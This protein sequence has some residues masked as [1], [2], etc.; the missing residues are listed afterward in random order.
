MLD[1]C[2]DHHGFRAFYRTFVKMMGLDQPSHASFTSH[3]GATMPGSVDHQNWSPSFLLGLAIKS[4]RFRVPGALV[5]QFPASY[6][7][8]H[9]CEFLVALGRSTSAGRGPTCNW[10]R[11]EDRGSGFQVLVG[12]GTRAP[13]GAC[14]W[15]SF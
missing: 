5:P 8:T 7:S 2:I 15:E 6:S 4:A 12:L 1:L 11:L 13:Q 14:I 10:T 9:T 3:S